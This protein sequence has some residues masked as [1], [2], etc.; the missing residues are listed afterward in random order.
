LSPEGLNQRFNNDA[1]RFLQRLLAFLMKSE[2]CSSG[3]IPCEYMAYF[4]RIR[5]LDSTIFQVPDSFAEYYPG[6]GGCGQ[7]AG[8]KIHLEY[9]LHSGKFLNLQWSLER[10]M[11]KPLVR[12]AYKLFGPATYVY[13]T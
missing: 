4:Q 2:I 8:I 7:T 10:I 12:L 9:D 6:S 1:V 13:E 11:I 5:I 3:V